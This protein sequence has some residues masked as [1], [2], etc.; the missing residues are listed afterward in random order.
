MSVLLAFLFV[1]EQKRTKFETSAVLSAVFSDE[2][3]HDMDKWRAGRTVEI[4][5]QRDPDC[6]ICPIS[7]GLSWFQMPRI[8]RWRELSKDW[9]TQPSRMT[10][11]SFFANNLVSTDISTDLNLPTGAKAFFVN[12]SDLGSTPADFEAK[13]PNHLGYFVVSHIGLNLKKDEALLYIDH[14]CADLCGG[15]EYI[16]MRKVNGAWHLVDRRGSWFS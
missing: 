13:Y 7:D 9:S 15:G 12:P 3:L 16:L 14:F 1:G 8:S 10:R 11:T 4:V 6:R 2:V 5:I